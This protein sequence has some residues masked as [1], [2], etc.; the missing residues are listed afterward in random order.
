MS[1]VEYAVEMSRFDERQTIDH[2]AEAGPLDTALVEAIADA[3][4]ASHAVAPL[5]QA[6]PWINSIPDI[7]EDNASGI[8]GSGLLCRAATSKISD[9]RR[10]P[11]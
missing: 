11:R 10:S 8:P 9:W 5:A 2:L 4:A 3:I 1:P 7:I 6:G